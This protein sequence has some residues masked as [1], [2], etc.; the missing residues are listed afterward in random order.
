[1]KNSTELLTRSQLA[2]R[3][4]CSVRKID[5]MR[6]L[7]LIPWIDLSAGKGSRATVRFKNT[8]IIEFETQNSK[9]IDTTAQA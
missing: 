9:S 3:W 7:G 5:R 6:D 8:T 4:N 2:K 1:M